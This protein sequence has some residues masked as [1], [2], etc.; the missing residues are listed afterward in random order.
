MRK[1]LLA[2]AVAIATMT[3]AA[4]AADISVGI[5]GDFSTFSN[6]ENTKPS[7]GDETYDSYKYS[8]MFTMLRVGIRASDVL[9]ISPY[10]GI[11]FDNYKAIDKKDNGDGVKE[12]ERTT[13]Q[14]LIGAGVGTYFHVINKDWFEL[15]MGPRL[16]W[17]MGAQPKRTNEEVED[18]KDTEYKTY[19][20]HTIGIDVPVNLDFLVGESFGIRLGTELAGFNITNETIEVKDSDVESKETDTEFSLLGLKSL[21]VS[22]GI[23]FRF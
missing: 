6:K 1:A 2:T 19:K 7:E 8:D 5:D 23:F 21:P 18:F 13:K 4:T 16:G 11:G 22:A 15:S 10:F 3:S 17:M 9:E 14:T 12:Y 20:K